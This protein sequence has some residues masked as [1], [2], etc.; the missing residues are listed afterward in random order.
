AGSVST[1]VCLQPLLSVTVIHPSLLPP[2]MTEEEVV[3]DPEGAGG[4]S[5]SASPVS[6]L[7]QQG[8]FPT[9][10][11]ELQK[12]WMLAMQ[13]P[14]GFPALLAQQ[15]AA[16]AAAAIQQ[17][18]LVVAGLAPGAP[19]VPRPPSSSS[20]SVAAPG[21]SG[22]N[23]SA[24]QVSK[25]CEMLEESGDV[26]SLAKFLYAL[27]RDVAEEVANQEPVLRSR[28]IVYFHMGMFAEMKAILASH[29]FAPACHAKLQMLW[30]EA[31]YQEAEKARGRP[32]GPVDKYRVRKKFPMPRT[33][34]DGEQ[35]TH[36]FKERTRSL[37]R[38]WYLKDPYPNPSKK[39]ELANATGLTAMQ[40]GNWFK[41]RRQRDRA[42]AAKNKCNVTGVELKKVGG[43]VGLSSD[44]EDDDFDDSTT[45]SPSPHDD[46]VADLSTT[47]LLGRRPAPGSL[48]PFAGALGLLGA[49]PGAEG[50]AF[51][52]MLLQM[53]MGMAGGGAGG[54]FGML[55]QL[56]QLAAANAA[57]AAAAASAASPTSAGRLPT[58]PIT[59]ATSTTTP[60]RSRLMID[61]ILNMK[62]SSAGSKEEAERHSA[63]PASAAS[64]GTTSDQSPTTSNTDDP[65]PIRQRPLASDQ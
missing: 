4:P 14:G 61:E 37:L 29:K 13:F 5:G 32:L 36:C 62:T 54:L 43:S 9:M 46:P 47:S 10:P 27:P 30:Q 38:E 21:S 41:N 64:S 56:Q 1:S 18:Q 28:A 65:S 57:A 45:D 24:D 40:V 25:R 60:K 6:M 42:A 58:P 20:D 3:L 48:P 33:I 2:E 31:H 23:V 53:M 7:P 49:G 44:D 11:A 8:V 17:P 63:S 51:N 26:D 34:W 52:P 19:L 12:M 55:P 15:A 35:K 59:P 39:K 16:A 22:A 50:S